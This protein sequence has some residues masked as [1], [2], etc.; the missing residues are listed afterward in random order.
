MTYEPVKYCHQL[1][2]S[3]IYNRS[4]PKLNVTHDT[5]LVTKKERVLF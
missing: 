4:A 3:K 1:Q 5:L 2:S